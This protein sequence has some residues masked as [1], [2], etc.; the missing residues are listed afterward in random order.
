MNNFFKSEGFILIELIIS[1][2]IF[3]VFA[4]AMISMVLGSFSVMQKNSDY[5]FATNLNQEN[6]EAVRSIKERGWNMLK[7]NKSALIF[8]NEWLLAGENTEERIDKFNRYIKFSNVYRNS[9]QEIVSFDVPGAI[10]DVNSLNIN[11]VVNWEDNGKQFSVSNKTMFTN[12]QSD[13]WEQNS[14]SG[15]PSQEIYIKNDMFLSS[16]NIK[17]SGDLSLEEISTSTFNI[18]GVLESSF[19]GPVGDGVFSSISWEENIPDSCNECLIKVQIKTAEDLSGVPQ[20]WSNTW[21]GP[22]GE[23]NDSDDY[24]V[25]SQGELISVDHNSDKWIKYK[26]TIEGSEEYTPQLKKIKIYYK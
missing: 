24:F 6:I 3:V 16:L 8:E 25:S 13:I 5:S 26:I 1:V 15:G 19:F 12:W 20:N 17:V 23:N 4:G 10:N 7:F 14:W 22:E 18:S 21:C 9:E 11:S 2:A